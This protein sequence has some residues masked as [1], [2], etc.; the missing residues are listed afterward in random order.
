M[1]VCEHVSYC[2]VFAGY[3]YHEPGHLGDLLLK[4]VKNST[5]LVHDTTR[6]RATCV[7]TQ[8][9]MFNIAYLFR[10]LLKTLVDLVETVTLHRTNSAML[11]PSIMSG[12]HASSLEVTHDQVTLGGTNESIK[13]IE[14]TQQ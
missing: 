4:W 2:D 12:V 7:T 11:T 3:L 1:Y 6:W 13:S 10:D 9:E 5:P 14:S 8:E